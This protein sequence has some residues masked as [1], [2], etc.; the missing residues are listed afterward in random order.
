MYQT[1]LDAQ[2]QVAEQ[3]VLR[4]LSDNLLTKMMKFVLN[5]GQFYLTLHREQEELDSELSRN[6][7]RRKAESEEKQLAQI[8]LTDAILMEVR[9]AVNETTLKDSS[10][11]KSDSQPKEIEPR[12]VAEKPHLAESETFVILDDAIIRTSLHIPASALQK[13]E[14]KSFL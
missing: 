5:P 2:A 11:D 14:G 12:K 8:L 7:Q 10:H 1:V 9:K 13:T 6:R 4:W 3:Q